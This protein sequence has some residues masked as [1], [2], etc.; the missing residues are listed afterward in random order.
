MYISLQLSKI[1]EKVNEGK[2]E[3]H[4]NEVFHVNLPG[5]LI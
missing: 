5:E 1:N 2:N 4:M 3:N